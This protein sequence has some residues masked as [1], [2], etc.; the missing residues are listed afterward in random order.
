MNLLVALGVRDSA[1]QDVPDEGSFHTCLGGR[2]VDQEN[3]MRAR[4]NT[5][6]VRLVAKRRRP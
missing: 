1:G 4:P 2:A 5:R 3:A 6:Y